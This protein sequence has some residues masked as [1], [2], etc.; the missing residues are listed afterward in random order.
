MDFLI[1]KSHGRSGRKKPQK[2]REANMIR[3]DDM[4]T[5]SE[6]GKIP[7]GFSGWAYDE[8]QSRNR[9][10]EI[11]LGGAS[12]GDRDKFD[13]LNGGRINDQYVEEIRK[14]QQDI[15]DHNFQL[16]E[17]FT[18]WLNEAYRR[19]PTERKEEI[20]QM[21]QHMFPEKDPDPMD[22][23]IRNRL[24]GKETQPQLRA[25]FRSS[26]FPDDRTDQLHDEQKSA[27][28]MD[29][30]MRKQLRDRKKNGF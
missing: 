4:T 3:S 20:Q 1:P 9:R 28:P 19:Q 5:N 11:V 17:G 7:S 10:R 2:K 27:H 29:E 15:H 12:M 8:I 13:E 14:T 23:E 16:S 18:Q 24:F 6:K 26:F 30:M 25:R 22:Q 21:K